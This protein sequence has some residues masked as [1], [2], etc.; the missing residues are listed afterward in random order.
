MLTMNNAQPMEKETKT[1]EEDTVL[2][3][4][5]VEKYFG[6]LCAVSV[7][8]LNINDGEFF[9]LVGPS[10]SGKSTLLRMIAGLNQPTSGDIYLNGENITDVPANERK[11]AL[12]F[13]NFQLFPHKTVGE[14][15]EFPLKMGGVSKS[16]RR[17]ECKEILDFVDLSGY[18]DRYPKQLSGGEQQRVSL[19]R[20]LIYEPDVLLLDEPLGSLDRNL[21][22]KLQVELRKFQRRLD[23][24]FIYVTHD[25]KVAL[26]VS[27]RLGVMNDSNIV[28]VGE[29]MDVYNNPSSKFVATFLGEV[30]TISGEV[31]ALDADQATLSVNNTSLPG[32]PGESLVVGEKGLFCCKSENFQ[33]ANKNP[34]SSHRIDGIVRDKVF[35]GK[36]INYYVQPK[37]FDTDGEDLIV[38]VS[39]QQG[40][41]ISVNDEL[42]VTWAPEDV[43]IFPYSEGE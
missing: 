17:K 4:D 5:S 40:A 42:T 8:E 35:S 9:T 22:E 19:A 21:K 23:I 28:Q 12:I 20:G 39:R 29:P 2:R 25:Q 33:I 37:D 41:D 11:T 1:E 38:S 7:P 27:D 13:Q 15:I 31:S 30:N 43:Q 32:R 16:E 10:G 26:T 34:S 3:I 6:D 18:Y 36:L 24:T 14:N